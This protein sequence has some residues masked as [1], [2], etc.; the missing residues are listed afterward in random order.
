[1]D[2]NDI[3][4]T[5]QALTALQDG[6]NSLHTN[7]FDEAVT[8]PTVGSVRRAV[9]IQLIINREAGLMKNENPTQGA[10]VI[11]ELTDLVETAVLEEFDR[12][13]QRGGVLGAMETLYQRS[14]IQ[15]ESL[16]YEQRKHSGELEIIGVNTFLSPDASAPPVS[17]ESL[18][19]SSEAEK[20]AQ[21]DALAH[22]HAHWAGEAPAAL[23]RLKD[24]ARRGENVFDVLLETVKVASLGQ[25]SE[26][27]FEVGGRYRRAM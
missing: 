19:R 25:T 15:E 23:A 13:S 14:R 27:L 17:I 10:H 1:M 9:A 22:F 18:M 4:T 24:A 7:A 16:R 12:L 2:F 21:L 6:C 3:R 11:D 8:T 20:R 26:A 5:L